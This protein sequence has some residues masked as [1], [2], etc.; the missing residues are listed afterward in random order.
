MLKRLQEKA[1]YISIE[2]VIV[3]GLMICL[4]VFAINQLYDAGSLVTTDAMDRINEVLT[5]APVVA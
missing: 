1:G 3:A 4:G 5:V 2:T